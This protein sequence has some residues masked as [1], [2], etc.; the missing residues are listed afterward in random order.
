VESEGIIYR[1]EVE[2]LKSEVAER[3]SQLQWLQE[4]IGETEFQKKEATEAIAQ[5]NRTL[6]IQKNSTSAEVFRLKGAPLPDIRVIMALIA[7][8]INL[9][10]WRRSIW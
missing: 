4:K 7:V 8:Q 9:S 2:S 5:A 3:T 10:S 6:Q 1:V